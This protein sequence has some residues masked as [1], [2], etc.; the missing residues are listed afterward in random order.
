M[1][2][3]SRAT[4][5]RVCEA[6]DA[7]VESQTIEYGLMRP[8][9]PMFVVPSS[10]N[11][12]PAIPEPASEFVA[13]RETDE[14]ET[15]ELFDGAVRVTEGAVV[16]MTML[17]LAER[18]SAGEKFVIGLLSVEVMVPAT[19]ATFSAAVFSPPAT[20]YV[21]D[22]VVELE[23][24]ENEQ[25]PLVFKVTTTLPV[26]LT[27]FEKVRSI[28]MEAPALY[29]P[30]ATVEVIFDMMGAVVFREEW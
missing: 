4:A 27:V 26:V 30:F 12:T 14:P 13:E 20:V 17:L 29:A 16:S 5:A 9:E 28:S 1:P 7:A 6:F 21:Q 3:A 15:V 22:A 25:V 10:L 8:S 18:L 11:W 24:P 19:L 2:A 23:T